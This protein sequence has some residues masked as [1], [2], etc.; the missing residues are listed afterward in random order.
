MTAID[1]LIYINLRI[2]LSLHITLMYTNNALCV[3]IFKP[4]S[5]SIFNTVRV[6]EIFYHK[7]MKIS[8]YND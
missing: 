8:C 5:L 1:T 4:V 7:D 3:S 2:A 6:Q